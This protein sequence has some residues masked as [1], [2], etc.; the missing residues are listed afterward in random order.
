LAKSNT[1]PGIEFSD[2]IDGQFFDMI[3]ANG[4]S[5]AMLIDATEGIENYPK[6]LRVNPAFTANTG[7]SAHEA[8]GSSTEIMLGPETDR[9]VLARFRDAARDLKSVRGDLAI[10][11]KSGEVRWVESVTTPFEVEGRLICL[12]VHRDISQRKATED[13]L[14]VQTALLKQAEVLGRIGHWTWN[15]KTDHVFWSDEIYRIHGLDHTDEARRGEPIEYYHDEDRDD[16]RRY[17]GAA[18]RDGKNFEFVLRAVRVDGQVRYV[19]TKGY[20]RRD[21]NGDVSEIFGVFQDVTDV[22]EIQIALDVERDRLTDALECISG[23]VLI[24]DKDDC[25][26]M[27]NDHYVSAVPGLTGRVKPGVPFREIVALVIR[28]R[29][30]H[31]LKEDD[32]AFVADRMAGHRRH[33]GVDAFQ[34]ADGRWFT[35]E[36]HAMRDGGTLV[37]RLDI[38]QHVEVQ[39]ALLQAKEDAEFASRSKSDF[40]ANM[41]HELR[42]PLNAIIGFG[43]M[44]KLNLFG[45]LPERYRDYAENIVVSGAHLLEII[46]DIL[47]IAKIEGGTIRLDRSLE[48]IGELIENTVPLVRQAAVTN[49]TLIFADLEAD[50]PSLYCDGLRIKQILL[51]LLSNAVKFAPDGTVMISARVDA[52]AD[53]LEIDV[54][55]DGIGMQ[56]DDV[57]LALTPFGQ[58]DNNHMTRQFQGTGLGL[59]LARNLT[60]LHGGEFALSSQSGKGTRVTL[61]FPLGMGP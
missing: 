2:L 51:N 25:V 12:L 30:R 14:A 32:D 60:K 23:G 47:D 26:V 19:D 24:L 8:V 56:P 61:R 33:E 44:M 4:Q 42:T 18:K 15:V 31:K 35:I 37:I 43:E 58:I 48:D 49:R 10:R 11:T 6:I 34:L 5:P 1:I 20:C 22:R 53:V 39:S 28:A 29:K 9:A 13:K 41:S 59:P 55:D 46:N 27:A 57:D 38:T 52:G 40:L 17:F 16:F 50:L 3:Y 45:E 7:F 21:E 54:A 36:E